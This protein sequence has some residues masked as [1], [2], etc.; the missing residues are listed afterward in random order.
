MLPV[1]MRHKGVASG[2]KLRTDGT[3]KARCLQMFSFDVPRQGCTIFGLIITFTA[4]P[5][6][7]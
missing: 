4:I 6:T 7:V 2:A 1:L 3:F 5:E